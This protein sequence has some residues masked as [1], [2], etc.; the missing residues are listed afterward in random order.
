MRRTLA[1]QRSLVGSRKRFLVWP[2]KPEHLIWA[3]TI[4]IAK[5][6][7]FGM[8]PLTGIEK[9]IP[10]KDFRRWWIVHLWVEQSFEFFAARMNAYLLMAV[11][12]VSRTLAERSVYFELI[13]IFLSGMICTGHH[14]YWV[15]GP[16]M[17]VPMGIMLSL[18]EFLPLVLLIIEALNQYL[19]IKA[20][21]LFNYVI[22]YRYFI[23][24]AFWNFVGVGVRRPHT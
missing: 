9:S 19:L 14:L 23:G 6:N 8:T 5:L 16:S 13:L 17:W 12:L 10:I 2:H 22:A 3:S 15:G 24:A 18:V 21:D 1:K 20:A 7:A 11:G 4:N